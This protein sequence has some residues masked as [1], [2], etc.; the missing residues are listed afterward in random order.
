MRLLNRPT[1]LSGMQPPAH[2]WTRARCKARKA[3]LARKA[4]P[5]SKA[6]LVTTALPALKAWQVL[7]APRVTRAIPEL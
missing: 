5:V 6:Q 4:L 7:M 1:A 3:L 2:G